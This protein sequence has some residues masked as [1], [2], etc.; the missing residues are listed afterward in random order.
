MTKNN[1]IIKTELYNSFMVLENLI[2]C[3]SMTIVHNT[4][5]KWTNHILTQS[6]ISSTIYKISNVIIIGAEN[7]TK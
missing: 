2:H 6:F 3:H 1:S 7:V 4:Y 5:H